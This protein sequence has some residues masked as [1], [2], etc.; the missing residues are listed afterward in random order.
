[1]KGIAHFSVG[2]A[3]ASCLPGVVAAGAAGNPWYFVLGGV[4]GLLP[5]TI[6]FRVSRF[7]YRHDMEV[8]PDPHA[9]DPVMIARALAAAVQQA[10]DSGRAVT[11][12]L[13]TVQ[14]GTD[15]W[16][17]YRVLFRRAE[18]CVVVS[19]GPVVDTGQMPLSPPTGGGGTGHAR[20]PCA[21]HSQ[22][23]AET[24]IDIFDGPVVRMVPQ[25]D[26]DVLIE[27]IPWH[28]LWT[29][30]F[31][32]VLLAGLGA[33][34][35]WGPLAGL[36]AG[37]ALLAHALADQ[38]GHM[39]SSLLFPWVRRRFEGMKWVH[40]GDPFPNIAAVWLSGLVILWN[41]HNALPGMRSLNPLKFFVLGALVPAGVPWVF[42]WWW[43]VLRR[44]RE[45]GSP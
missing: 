29:H 2:V 5:D 26:G 34:A 42:R 39:G 11:V 9:P 44:R 13:H 28:R 4:F 16:Q 3:W 30:S 38:L 41:L 21:V 27:F 36:V 12:K 32:A 8:S 17:S 25:A 24:V 10:R 31:T 43:E 37:G 40:S 6:D 35:L 14:V 33:G 45:S 18:R 22:Y 23:Q 15:A 19:L 20:L 1:M 7:L